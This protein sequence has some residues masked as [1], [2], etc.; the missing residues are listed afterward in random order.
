MAEVDTDVR[1]CDEDEGKEIVD[2]SVGED[3]GTFREG[4]ARV[5]LPMVGVGPGA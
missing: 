3:E 2:A 4:G 1:E 5:S